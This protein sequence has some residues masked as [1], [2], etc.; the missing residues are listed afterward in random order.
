MPT[1]AV[2]PFENLSGDLEQE[3]FSDGITEDVITDL[4]HFRDLDVIAR[5]STMVYKGKLADAREVG[6]AL[7]VRY[8]LEGSIQRQ[9]SGC[10]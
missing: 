2:L 6:R 7:D 5:N 9:G 8:V 4:A 1:I 10:A 3:Y